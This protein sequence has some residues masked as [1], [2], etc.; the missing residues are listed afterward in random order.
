MRL[1]CA[2]IVS[3]RYLALRWSPNN[4]V[5]L[6]AG[7]HTRFTNDPLRWELWVDDHLGQGTWEQLRDIAVAV[8]PRPDYEQIIAKLERLQRSG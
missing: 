2:H 5:T 7:C 4:A 3:R 6:C 8:T 1:Q